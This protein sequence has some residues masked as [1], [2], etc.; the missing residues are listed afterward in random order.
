MF[1]FQALALA[2]FA[3]V[4]SIALA[5]VT[6]LKTVQTVYDKSPKI[7]IR[8][9]GFDA[10]D[11]NI[12]LTIGATGQDPLK[13]D[14][15]FMISKDADGDGIILKLIGKRKWADL[16]ERTP[17]VALIL[18]AVYFSPDTKKNLLPEPVIVAQ[19]L[20]TPSV[21]ENEDVI[22]QTAT[23]E[24]RIN[25]TGFIGAKKVDFYFKPPLVKEVAYEDVSPYPLQKDEVILRLRH[26]YNWRDSAGELSV[27]G[28]DTGGGPVKLNGDEGVVV[29][30][31]EKNLDAH[32][33][34]VEATVDSQHLYADDPTLVITGSNFNEIGNNLRFANGILGNNVNYTTVSTTD[35][36]RKSV[37]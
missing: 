9:S 34:R 22:Y 10:E 25:G 27:V 19:I 15:D 18:S 26:N 1:I 14:K 2:T 4:C 33:V 6:V 16:S 23:N 11:H 29:A 36:D 5:E 17:P 35:E 20:D 12:V 32:A 7:R 13:V 21:D 31:V 37:V 24:L 28:I 8:G 30:N 3:C